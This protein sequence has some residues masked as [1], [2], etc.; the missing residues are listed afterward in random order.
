MVGNLELQDCR[1]ANIRQNPNPRSP[2]KVSTPPALRP[3]PKPQNH[4]SRAVHPDHTASYSSG[5]LRKKRKTNSNRST[6]KANAQLP[7]AEGPAV[8]L[9]EAPTLP[10]SASPCPP[11]SRSS[12]TETFLPPYAKTM[13]TQRADSPRKKPCYPTSS[14]S[15]NSHSQMPSSPRSPSEKTSERE[16]GGRGRARGRRGNPI[17]ERRKCLP[18]QNFNFRKDKRFAGGYTLYFGLFE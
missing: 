16:G 2:E 14:D 4:T 18:K 8:G 10:R 6:Q 17:S 5:N 9:H 12:R 11:Y 7:S 3:F 1:N 15:S 13:A